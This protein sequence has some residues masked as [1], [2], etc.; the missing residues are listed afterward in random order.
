MLSNLNKQRASVYGRTLYL[1]I[2]Q[3]NGAKKVIPLDSEKSISSY[4]INLEWFFT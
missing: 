1:I 4:K 2:G 3:L